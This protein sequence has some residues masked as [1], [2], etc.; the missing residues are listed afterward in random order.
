[1]LIIDNP[2]DRHARWRLF[3]VTALSRGERVHTLSHPSHPNKARR[4][5]KGATRATSVTRETVKMKQKR[6]TSRIK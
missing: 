6:T 3:G 1:M 2:Y 5:D 4:I